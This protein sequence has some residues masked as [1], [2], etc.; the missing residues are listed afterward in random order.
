MLLSRPQ[1]T[2]FALALQFEKHT[3]SWL[4]GSF[5]NVLIVVAGGL[6]AITTLTLLEVSLGPLSFYFSQWAGLLIFLSAVVFV[7][8]SWRVFLE[9]LKTPHPGL[10]LADAAPDIKAG[11]AN[12]ATWMSYDAFRM[13][14]AAEGLSQKRPA[15]PFSTLLFWELLRLPSSQFILMRLGMSPEEMRKGIEERVKSGPLEAGKR[16]EE[17]LMLACDSAAERKKPFLTVGDLL[18]SLAKHDAFFYNQLFQRELDSEDV[19]NI[20]YW[21]ESIEERIRNRERFWRYENLV[22]APGIGRDWAAGWT[23]LVDQFSQDIT[24]E[25]ERTGFDLH[26]IGRDKELKEMERILAASG[27]HNVLV[28]GETGTGKETVVYGLGKLILQ[29]KSLPELKHKRMIR[30]DVDALLAGLKTPGEMSERLIFVFN[31][32]VRA[33]NVL[34]VIESFDNFTGGEYGLGKVD[35]TSIIEPYLESK[36]LQVIGITDLD[37]YH[38]AI[39][40][41]AVL[42]KAFERVEVEEPDETETILI[43]E[44]VVPSIEA[45]HG[46]F[47]TYPAIRDTV[48]K[49]AK[50][51]QD[52]AMPERA[53]NLLSEVA[54]YVAKQKKGKVITSQDIDAVLTERTGIPIGKMAEKERDILVN[55][56]E[57][58]H[59]RLINQEEAVRAVASAMRRARTGLASE[60]RPVGSF[61]FLGPTGVGKTETAK[62]LARAYFGKEDA[63]IRFDMSEY[64]DDSSV[65]RFL[66]SPERGDAGDLP[67][68][69]RDNPFSLILFDEIDKAYPRILDLFLQILDEGFMTDAFGKRVNFTNTI[70]ISTSNAGA[71]L[72]K[73]YVERSVPLEKVRE[74]VLDAIQKEGV[75]RPEFINR[76]DGTIVFQPLS[77]EHLLQISDL[78]LRDLAERLGEKDIAL[79]ITPELK[80][81]VVKLGYQPEFGARPMRRVIQ[82]KIE[83]QIAKKL[84][85]GTIKRGD[86]ITISPA[87]IV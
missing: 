33:R 14:V 26:L 87:E 85:S 19:K 18:T 44:D 40:R 63:M 71:N 6:L 65:N 24:E 11:K 72:I 4:F 70:I 82:E 29:G 86:T 61:L 60:K 10:P 57:I 36:H 34:L 45:T 42:T 75:F 74:I 47:V 77:H 20:S 16:Y 73:E 32:M 54:V 25:I 1:K 15:I 17:I 80:E 68:A 43:L 52:V 84:L 64:Q 38:R 3:P 22:R 12:V 62:A 76:F 41:N 21:Q 50:Y 51:L 8:V 35:I 48:K 23:V 67:K 53:I 13:V 2:Y 49:A 37:G 69:V 58:L 66:G 83:D 9:W 39:E 28:V 31:E 27:R 56:E 55:L 79:V 7:L 46:V 5:A 30:L 59:K 81:K 78:M